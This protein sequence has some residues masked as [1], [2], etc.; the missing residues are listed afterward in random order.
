MGP[1]MLPRFARNR[2]PGKERGRHTVPENLS[3]APNLCP[4]APASY[5][6]EVPLVTAIEVRHPSGRRASIP[7]PR[8][9]TQDLQTK[10][11]RYG[12]V[13]NRVRERQG[14][15]AAHSAGKPAAFRQTIAKRYRC[16]HNFLSGSLRVAIAT[17][18]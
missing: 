8:F 3:P 1:F 4:T 18:A 7:L 10:P 5:V 16:R 12:S 13:K 15:G 2:E 14:E 17:T 9:F 6:P 11:D